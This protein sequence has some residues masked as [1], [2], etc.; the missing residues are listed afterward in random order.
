MTW[1]PPDEEEEVVSRS[2]VKEEG[3]RDVVQFMSPIMY[4]DR[5]DGVLVVEIMRI[6]TFKGRCSVMFC[7]E[8]GTATDGDDYE[9]TSSEVV[10][11]EG[12]DMK[13]VEVKIISKSSFE[14]TEFHYTTPHMQQHH[15]VSID[16]QADST[17]ASRSVCRACPSS[18]PAD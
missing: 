17:A 2:D 14:T 3:G 16:S 18:F 15:C 8:D 4:A 12:E 10:F 6:G 13:A 7:T 9:A 1:T 5:D 11:E